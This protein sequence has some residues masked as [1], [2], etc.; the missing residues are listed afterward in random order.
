MDEKNAA[1]TEQ[2][3]VKMESAPDCHHSA[4]IS[5]VIVKRQTRRYQRKRQT[6]CWHIMRKTFS[7]KYFI[8][9]IR[10]MY[11]W[12]WEMHR[13][14]LRARRYTNNKMSLS[15]ACNKRAFEKNIYRRKKQRAA[16]QHALKRLF[17]YSSIVEYLW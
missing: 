11:G 9:F 4:A 6:I 1:S 5:T 13:H 3:S 8:Y 2:T 10:K 16:Q 14:T 7:Y 15:C 12:L 17:L